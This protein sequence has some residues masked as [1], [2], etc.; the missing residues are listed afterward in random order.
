[1]SFKKVD[2]FSVRGILEAIE[3]LQ[4]AI[5]MLRPRE[6]SGTLRSTSSTGTITKAS[7]AAKRQSATTTTSNQPSRWQ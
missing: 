4:E 7:K 5:N 2:K 1:M 6:S 3:E